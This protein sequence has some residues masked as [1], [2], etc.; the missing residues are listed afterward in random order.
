MF[1][2]IFFLKWL[3]GDFL[4]WEKRIFFIR[5]RLPFF[6]ENKIVIVIGYYFRPLFGLNLHLCQKYV[7]F[8]SS[9]I[10]DRG[11][12]TD[13]IICYMQHGAGSAILRDIKT[14]SIIL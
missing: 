12:S 6:T 11:K 7:M 3:T 9:E 14:M 8:T 1:K 13:I 2:A 5:L 4:A 10:L